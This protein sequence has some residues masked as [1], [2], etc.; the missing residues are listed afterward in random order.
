MPIIQDIT[1][2]T[3][4]QIGVN[5]RT[6]RIVCNDS[7][8]TVTSAGY[9]NPTSL[10]GYTMLPTDFV[11]IMYGANS[12]TPGIFTPTITNGI[13]TLVELPNTSGGVILPVVNGNFAVFSGTSGIISD[14]GYAPSDTGYNTVVMT[15]NPG[16]FASHIGVFADTNGT[17]FS[18]AATA[19]NGGD[20]QAGDWAH[21][22]NGGFI[23]IPSGPNGHLKF[24]ATNNTSN[25]ATIVTNAP[26]TVATTISIP[27][28]GVSA[29]NF[30]LSDS[31]GTQHITSGDFEVDNGNIIAG[32]DGVSGSF[33]SFPLGLGQGMLSF[34]ASP[35]TADHTVILT[36]ANSFAQTTTLTLPDPGISASNLLVSDFTGTQHITSGSLEVDKGNLTAGSD[37]NAGQFISYPAGSAQGQLQVYATANPGNFLT[38]ITNSVIGQESVFS[39][40]DP[41]NSNANFIVSNFSGTQHITSGSLSVDQGSIGAGTSGHAGTLSSFPTTASSGRLVLDA[42]DSPGGFNTTISNRAMG[43]GTVFSIGDPGQ[44]TASIL[45]SKVVADVGA[46]LISFDVTVSAAALASGGQVVLIASS[47]SKQFKMRSLQLNQSATSFTGGGGDRDGL[48]TDGAATVFTDIPAATMQAVDNAT[49]GSTDL[50]FPTGQSLNKSS[51]AGSSII[52]EYTAGSADYASGSLVISGIVERVA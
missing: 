49:W 14:A 34:A 5:P 10:Q 21:S 27:D 24:Q 31:S 40:P 17:L 46:N 50:P 12:N 47:G 28:S 37:N 45:T 6:V 11:F 48:I 36:N 38:I 33:I 25:V 9:L 39:L 15:E 20:I 18:D 19:I 1:T 2:D 35:V 29:T 41:S 44:A 7:L 26:Q 43:Q 4:G 51:A 16:N 8:G 3:A 42:V 23:S 32:S 13:I 22:S 30:L 52:F